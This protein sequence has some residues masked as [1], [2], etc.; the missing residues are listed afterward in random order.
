M[1]IASD[2]CLQTPALSGQAGALG[3]GCG[4]SGRGEGWQVA[5]RDWCGEAQRGMCERVSVSVWGGSVGPVGHPTF[6]KPCVTRGD[7]GVQAG[8]GC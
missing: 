5:V 6:A 4:A 8:Q 1:I 7:H 2:K 3:G